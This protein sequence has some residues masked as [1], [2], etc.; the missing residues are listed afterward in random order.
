MPVEQSHNLA[1]HSILH[2]TRYLTQNKRPNASNTLYTALHNTHS[3]HKTLLLYFLTGMIGLGV[4]EPGQM[5]LL[6]GSSH[7]QLVGMDGHNVRC[8]L[9][10]WP[11]VGPW[12]A[13]KLKPVDKE[14]PCA[15]GVHWLNVQCSLYKLA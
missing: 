12:H 4:V 9:N 6:T 14:Q 2:K 5:A 7:L 15:A 3:A 13:R 10:H 1:P 8:S 11:I